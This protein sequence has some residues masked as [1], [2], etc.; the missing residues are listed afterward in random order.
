M[1]KATRIDD[2]NEEE[3]QWLLKKKKIEARRQRLKQFD[4]SKTLDPDIAS[5]EKKEWNGSYEEALASGILAPHRKKN[6]I[7]DKLLLG[8]EA[9]V[10]VG[11]IILVYLGFTSLRSLNEV[12]A[13][14]YAPATAMPTP[15]IRPVV[16]PGGHKPPTDPGGARFNEEEIPEHLR[17]N[18]REYYSSLVIPTPMPET[19][20]RIE[21]PAIE[22]DAPIVQG[23]G[24]EQLKQGVGQHIGTGLPG[25]PGNMVLSAHNDIYG[26]LFRYLDRLAPGDEIIIHSGTRTFT[27]VVQKTLV[28]EPSE[29]WVMDPVDET[30]VSLIS[31]YPYLIDNKRI[32]VRAELQS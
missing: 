10:F 29:V 24:W 19:A 28:V 13:A 26:E 6:T 16:I 2:L 30:I 1:R 12:F 22:I 8:I 3:I 9:S 25:Q 31:C 15:M 32:V 17:A 23:D 20:I 27:Y 21:I 14:A 4:R 7:A 5:C 11:L 18:V